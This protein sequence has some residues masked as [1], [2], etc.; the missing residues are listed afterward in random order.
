MDGEIALPFDRYSQLCYKS[1]DQPEKTTF[2]CSM[3]NG[4]NFLELP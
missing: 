1:V 2:I 4:A 3:N